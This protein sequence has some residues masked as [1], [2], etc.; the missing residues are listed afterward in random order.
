MIVNAQEVFNRTLGNFAVPAGWDSSRWRPDLFIA[1]G[2]TA[3]AVEATLFDL[4][5]SACI[6][7][8]PTRL[9]ALGN[10]GRGVLG[11][12]FSAR[13]AEVLD[14]LDRLR[15]RGFTTC[16]LS[17]AA[18]ADIRLTT[19]VSLRPLQ[20]IAYCAALPRLF[21]QRT[22][23]GGCDSMLSA[24]VLDFL[25]DAYSARLTPIFVGCGDGFAS[26]LLCGYWL[27]FLRRPAFLQ[28][29]PE[30]THD[31]F[32]SMVRT[33]KRFA[34]IVE[35]PVHDLTDNRFK[36]TCG[37]LAEQRLPFLVLQPFGGSRAGQLM[38]AADGFLTLAYQFGIDLSTELEFDIKGQVNTT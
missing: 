5:C 35:Q 37:W 19:E 10:D 13:S 9:D 25:R 33:G 1:S 26:R 30:W 36:H 18:S 6:I 21:A 38:G 14:G 32:W 4:G 3:L 8:D 24:C 2:L 16:L 15:Q 12:S 27:E 7:T 20:H 22:V 31:F 34:L 29:H 17:A 23:G 28:H 11:C